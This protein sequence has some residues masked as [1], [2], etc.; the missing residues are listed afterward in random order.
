[1]II[2]QLI[3]LK[4]LMPPLFPHSGLVHRWKLHLVHD[5][6]L[7]NMLQVLAFFS[8]FLR[9]RP[10]PWSILSIVSCLLRCC[11][12]QQS[13]VFPSLPCTP[14]TRRRNTT[15]SRRDTPAP[16][17]LLSFTLYLPSSALEHTFYI[18][19]DKMKEESWFIPKIY[20]AF[21][22]NGANK[23]KFPFHPHGS[24]QWTHWASRATAD[25]PARS[26]STKSSD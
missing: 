19:Q 10:W 2:R 24:V 15:R 5:C 18:Y 26:R 16:H 20:Q 11:W 8:H 23:H 14:S 12:C 22:K 9:G 25:T 13:A 1:M 4:H 17:R 3:G 21:G 6:F 7:V